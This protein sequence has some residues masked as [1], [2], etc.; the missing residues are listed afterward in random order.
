M[1]IRSSQ[2]KKFVAT[3]T[4]HP[5][6]E[7]T[8]SSVSGGFSFGGFSGDFSGGGGIAFSCGHWPRSGH[9]PSSSVCRRCRH[10]HPQLCRADSPPQA[11]IRRQG[12]SSRS[13]AG[14][15]SA[16]FALVPACSRLLPGLGQI[17]EQL[18]AHTKVQPLAGIKV[19]R[20]PLPTTCA[21]F[22]PNARIWPTRKN[23]HHWLPCASGAGLKL[24]LVHFSLS[25]P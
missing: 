14:W 1:T 23:Q 8:G 4:H 15:A 21:A 25:F 24:D 12:S 20:R 5:T 3:Q 10:P 19:Y 22:H 7:E 2:T 9:M 17:R 11:G 18:R 16:A 6:E 13:P